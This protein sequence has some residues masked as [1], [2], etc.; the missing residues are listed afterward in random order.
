VRT[1]TSGHSVGTRAGQ[2]HGVHMRFEL[3]RELPIPVGEQIKTQIVHRIF[4][5]RL[6][7][8]DRLPS[9]RELASSMGVSYAT[10]SHIYR[11]L[12]QDR[13]VVT[14]PGKGTYVADLA[15]ITAEEKQ[16][17]SGSSLNQLAGTF[18]SQSLSLGYGASE[19]VE[20]VRERLE[21]YPA[22]PTTRNIVFVGGVS[23]R[24][25]HLYAREIEA[26][27][28]DLEVSVSVILIDELK[29]D[30]QLF[31]ERASPAKLVVTLPTLLHDTRE[32][33]EP[34]GYWLSSIA[35]R[36]STQTVQQLS[37]IDPGCRVG[38]VASEPAYLMTLVEQVASYSSSALSMPSA[39]LGDEPRLQDLLAGVDIVIYHSGCERILER[40]G[41]GIEA[42]E[43]LYSPE[44]DSV[45]RLRPLI[46]RLGA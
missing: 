21:G 7:P 29:A 14:R 6:R 18:V 37:A 20:A 24:A 46:T 8:G 43:F 33:L 15:Q 44:P 40:I 35:F 41:P 34:Q 42:I 45:L 17:M 22:S 19:V 23:R 10:I 1:T 12:A 25:A 30:P 9:L 4:S 38:V 32:L 26:L 36:P 3:D 31:L 13:L 11:D 2:I 27:L 28:S 5:S 39:V 16:R